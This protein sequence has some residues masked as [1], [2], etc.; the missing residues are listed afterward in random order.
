MGQEGP[1]EARACALRAAPLA[2][3]MLSL[4]G[5]GNDM[6]MLPALQKLL[7]EAE[8][9]YEILHHPT[10]YRARATAEDT[11]T[12]PV[13]FAKAVFLRID[14]GYAVAA[15]PATHFVAPSRMARAIGADEIRLASE[16]EM[17]KLCP[18]CEVGAA[19]PVGALFDLPTYASP[20]LARDERITFNAGSHQDAVRM[21]WDDFVLVARP[22]VVPLGRHEEE[23][24]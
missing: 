22:E 18:G 23:G 9:E 5:G 8:V 4:G 24:S 10:D 17:E 19:P 1:T 11:H 20:V 12:P 14:E 6:S 7:D 15:L 13:E 21:R 2:R 16:R 3:P